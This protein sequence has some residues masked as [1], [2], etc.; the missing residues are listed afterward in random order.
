MTSHVVASFAEASRKGKIQEIVGV[1]KIREIS[2]G[3]DWD[4]AAFDFGEIFLP[5]SG[6]RE[7]HNEMYSAWN[8]QNMSGEALKLPFSECL[9]VFNDD[10]EDGYPAI[11]IIHLKQ[12]DMHITADVY[13]QVS[14]TG[15]LKWLRDPYF[16]SI[17]RQSTLTVYYHNDINNLPPDWRSDIEREV[18]RDWTMLTIATTLL[19]HQSTT[20]EIQPSNPMLQSVNIG[21]AKA[22]LRSIPATITIKF[23]REAIIRAGHD[24]GGS[25]APRVPHNRRGHWRTY[26]ATGKRVWVRCCSINGGDRS[27]LYRIIT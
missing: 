5:K 6:N 8:E 2:C 26:K 7:L 20:H 15:S 1:N 27:R 4:I 9:Y 17:D 3:R 19:N 13:Q 23:D 11:S 22:G 21:R 16:F 24:N 25:R 10:Y 18:R 12:S 14:R